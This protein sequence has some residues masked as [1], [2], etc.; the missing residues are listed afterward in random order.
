MATDPCAKHKTFL[1]GELKTTKER[2][3]ACYTTGLAG[4]MCERY[5]PEKL[6]GWENVGPIVACSAVAIEGLERTRVT[7]VEQ[8]VA[9]ALHSTEQDQ[10]DAAKAL[11]NDELALTHDRLGQLFTKGLAGMQSSNFEPR[12]HSGWSN[13]GPIIQ[14]SAVA[15]K[16]L[17]RAR[18][19]L[20]ALS[21]KLMLAIVK[22]DAT[23]PC[24]E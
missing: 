22:K 11:V 18:G 9:L 10:L 7:V 2:L 15:I 14:C 19:K 12:N 6:L 3:T 16:A 24:D 5:T 4:S 13:V 8:L 23:I 1:E 21:T 20:V 17:E